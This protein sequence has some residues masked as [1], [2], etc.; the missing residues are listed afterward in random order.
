M[1]GEPPTPAEVLGQSVPFDPDRWTRLLPDTTLWPSE[2][3]RLPIVGRWP[4]V[5]RAAVLA[6]AARGDDPP[7]ALQTYVASSVW[8]SGTKARTVT[9]RIQVLIDTDPAVVGQR[10]S[11]ALATLHSAGAVEAYRRLATDLH[12][13]GLGPA[14]FTKLLY[15]AGT[16]GAAP[17]PG[18]TPLIL[19]RFVAA[20]LRRHG[21]PGRWA[22]TGWTSTRYGDYLE[23]AAELAGRWG[24]DVAPSAVELRLFELGRAAG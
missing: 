18:P 1:L 10:L 23:W 7:A 12:V 8:G 14:F 13:D 21:P 17:T 24:P 15:F 2:L 9:R 16:A 6:I 20:A 11:A 5:D 19:D 22:S 4:R 3:S